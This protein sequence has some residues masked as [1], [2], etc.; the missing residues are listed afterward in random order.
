MQDRFYTIDQVAELL[1]MHHKT[2]RKFIVDRQLKAGKVGKQ[3]RISG[4]D[5]SVFLERS[6]GEKDSTDTGAALGLDDSP[7]LT[8]EFSAMSRSPGEKMRKVKL[9]TVA[10]IDEVDKE[11]YIR[12]SNTLIAVANT[13]DAG[14]DSSS[15]QIRYD[16]K[17]RRLR[18]ILWGSIASTGRM[19]E[20]IS[21]LAGEQKQE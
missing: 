9:S 14:L 1:G 5:L 8:V 7:E 16:E 2:I 18:I 17:D 6:G 15:V 10:D 12:I 11:E 13:G 4:Q 21:M 3:W 20:T 19:L